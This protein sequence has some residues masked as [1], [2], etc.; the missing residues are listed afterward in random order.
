MILVADTSA[1]IALLDRSDRLHAQTLKLFE[2]TNPRWVLPWAI[3]AEVDYLVGSRLGD[4]VQATFF[5]ELAGAV[6]QVDWGGEQD[7]ARAW[8]LTRKYRALRLGLVDSVVMA[9]AERLRAQAIVTLDLRHFGAVDLEG[10][11]KLYPR[12]LPGRALTPP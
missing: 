4:R 1:I 12:D 10:A 8:E 6:W 7:L 11:P 9:T 2:G 3:L 5:E